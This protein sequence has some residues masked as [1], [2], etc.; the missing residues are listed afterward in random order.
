MAKAADA[1]NSALPA[2]A[3]GLLTLSSAEQLDES[4]S[5]IP[6]LLRTHCT[7]K[8]TM[9]QKNKVVEGRELQQ[10]LREK[11]DL[12][13]GSTVSTSFLAGARFAIPMLEP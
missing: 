10:K 8:I 2:P 11:K 1:S 6:A 13:L 7:S 5:Q 3:A 9:V 4:P 12:M